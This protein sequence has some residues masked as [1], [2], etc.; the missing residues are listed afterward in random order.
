MVPVRAKG[1]GLAVLSGCA[2][3]GIVNTI[4]HSQRIAGTDKL[5]AVLGEFHPINAKSE[6]IEK[7][8][9]DIKAMKPDHIVPTHCTGFEANVSYTKAMPAQFIFNASKRDMT[10]ARNCHGVTKSETTR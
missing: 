7:T 8:V 10:L 5:R 3:V 9:E 2:H 6:T 4:E 1:K